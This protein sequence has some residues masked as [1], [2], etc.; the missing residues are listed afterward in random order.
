M[1]LRWSSV[2]RRAF[3][4]VTSWWYDVEYYEARKIWTNTT[5]SGSVNG[6]GGRNILAGLECID[7]GQSAQGN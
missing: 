6:D 2:G 7:V 5:D 3:D 1:T 4:T